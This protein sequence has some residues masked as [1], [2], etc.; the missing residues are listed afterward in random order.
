MLENWNLLKLEVCCYLPSIL[1]FLVGGERISTE[2]A[3]TRL[4]SRNIVYIV[5][6]LAMLPETRKKLI[7]EGAIPHLLRLKLNNKKNRVKPLFVSSLALAFIGLEME[8]PYLS[9]VKSSGLYE[10]IL[11]C[12]N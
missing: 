8:E 4:V 7:V 11:D 3:K 12:V 2:L 6:K 10:H 1:T 9:I 5:R